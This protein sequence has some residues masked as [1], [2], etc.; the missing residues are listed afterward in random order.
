MNRRIFDT[1]SQ[2][3]KVPVS[4]I[5]SLEWNDPIGGTLTDIFIYGNSIQHGTPSNS[6]PVEI[7]SNEC[8]YRCCGRNMWGGNAL[9]SDLLDNGA[10]VNYDGSIAITAKMTKNNVT[11]LKTNFDANTPYTII[12]YGRSFSLI[13]QNTCIKIEYSDNSADELK[14]QNVDE[15][16][17]C[18]FTTPQDKQ[19]KRLVAYGNGE[20]S[21]LYCDKCG[22]FKG[23]L[24]LDD[25]E[26]YFD[27]GTIVVPEVLLSARNKADVWDVK[28]GVVT[29]N[30]EELVVNGT[31]IYTQFINN[32]YQAPLATLK[33]GIS[34]GG[35]TLDI[36]STH[37]VTG[38]SQKANYIYQTEP[39]MYPYLFLEDTSLT[40]AVK[41]NAWFKS[42]YDAGTPVRIIRSVR[43]TTASFTE[44][45]KLTS[46]V[47]FGQIIEIGDTLGAKIEASYISHT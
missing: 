34:P 19:I 21:L 45:Q 22:L 36:I 35:S 44:P 43:T 13:S 33:S 18:I 30:V 1:L 29:H 25:F 23:T 32:N 39:L 10:T 3:K 42:Q 47:G 16:C 46:P 41:A 4:G 7:T 38:V 14:F 26:D 24:T 12:L 27:G 20:E 5:G 17:Y 11:L 28:G 2:Y 40:T 9:K 31:D 15:E 6:S 37:F 8:K